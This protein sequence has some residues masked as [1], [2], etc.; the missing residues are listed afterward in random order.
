MFRINGVSK[1]T[2]FDTKPYVCFT[3]DSKLCALFSRAAL[4]NSSALVLR[5]IK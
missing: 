3:A 4:I 5:V 2:S 1:K